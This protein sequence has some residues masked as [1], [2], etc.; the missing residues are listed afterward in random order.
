MICMK[1][2]T[3]QGCSSP[4]RRYKQGWCAAH[5]ER[6][7][8][9]RDPLGKPKSRINY[10][11]VEGCDTRVQGR[12]YCLKHYKKFRKYGDPLESKK[13]SN[14]ELYR[15]LTDVAMKFEGEEC[16]KWPY[17][18]SHGR[19]RLTIPGSRDVVA[20]RYLCE[21]V[22]GPAPTPEHHAAHS[23]GKGDDGCVNPK[24]LRWASPSENEQDKV[25]HG[26][27][28]RGER[29]G[30]NKLTEK[31]VL[32]IRELAKTMRPCQLAKMFPVTESGIRSIR[33]RK[34]WA[35]LP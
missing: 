16:L 20:S 19:G 1:T 5:Y 15:F 23:C 8:R 17:A 3:I 12:G 22:Y 21:L 33:D 4:A 30:S 26:T 28:N 27:S 11:T 6:F 35:W 32:E 10:C 18:A 13:A 7:R 34:T 29:C 31:Q 25:T 2:C 24:H 9:Y 14:G